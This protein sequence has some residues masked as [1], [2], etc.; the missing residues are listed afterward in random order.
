MSIST[1]PIFAIRYVSAVSIAALV[2]DHLLTLER[3]I[4]LIWLN[5]TAGI[6]NRGGF[7]INRYLT[8]GVAI[9]MAHLFSG[10]A[11]N[12]TH[13]SCRAADWIFTMCSSVFITIS[14]FIIMWRVYT[15]WDRRRLVKWILMTVFFISSII[16]TTFAI[17]SAVQ[18]QDEVSYNSF[19][20]MCT[21]AQKPWGLKYTMAA[22]TGFD[23]FIIVL[24]I[25]NALDRPHKRQADV[26]ISLQHD[27]ARM[28]VCIFGKRRVSVLSNNF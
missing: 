27:G 28:F 17:L 22:L 5:P 26:M 13:E 4:M 3:E 12:I 16:A 9:Y 11:E 8:E 2:Y 19:I 6:L 25:I 15:L 20:H 1:S 14:Y 23:F 7:I 10:V 21:V 24:T 18:L